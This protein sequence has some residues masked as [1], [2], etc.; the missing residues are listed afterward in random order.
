MISVEHDEVL[1][2]HADVRGT[3]GEISFEF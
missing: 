2:I 3:L 1:D